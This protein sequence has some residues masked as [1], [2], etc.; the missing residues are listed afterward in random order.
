MDRHILG[1]DYVIK[2]IESR[3]NFMSCKF[4]VDSLITETESEDTPKSLFISLYNPLKK[5]T[6]FSRVKIALF[7]KCPSYKV[8]SGSLHMNLSIESIGGTHRV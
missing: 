7:L 3:V 5:I 4:K 1:V 6:S 2:L 8:L